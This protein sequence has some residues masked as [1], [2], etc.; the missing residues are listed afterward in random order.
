MEKGGKREEKRGKKRENILILFPCFI[1]A[2]MT[3]KKKSTKKTGNTF[4]SFHGGGEI[5]FSVAIIYTPDHRSFSTG[6]LCMERL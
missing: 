3:A 5:F 6:S 1:Y 2:L 4:E